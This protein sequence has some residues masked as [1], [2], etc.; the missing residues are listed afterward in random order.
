MPICLYPLYIAVLK[1][2]N[3]IWR[4]SVAMSFPRRMSI[5]VFWQQGWIFSNPPQEHHMSAHLTVIAWSLVSQ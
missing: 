1:Q 5:A 2:K 4:Q 3:P